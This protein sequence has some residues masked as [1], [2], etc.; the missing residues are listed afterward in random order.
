MN[1]HRPR[2][3][4]SVIGIGAGGVDLLTA[5]ASAALRELDAVIVISKGEERDHL[6]APRQVAGQG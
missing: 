5:E 1:D 4:V 3:Q 6:L 2:R